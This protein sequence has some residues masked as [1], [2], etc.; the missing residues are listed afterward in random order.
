MKQYGLA[1]EHWHWTRRADVRNWLAKNFGSE[2]QRWGEHPDYGLEN[3]WMNEDV[4]TAFLL[5]WS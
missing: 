1:I 2:G 3:L 5:R 4:Y